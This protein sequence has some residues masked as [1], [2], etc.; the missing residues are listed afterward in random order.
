MLQNIFSI[1]LMLFEVIRQIFHSVG[2]EASDI[3]VLTRVS[4]S[5]RS[6]T[7]LDVIGDFDSNFQTQHT[8]VRK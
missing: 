7:I 5:Q 6:N 4:N 1:Y 3:R 8:R 2:S